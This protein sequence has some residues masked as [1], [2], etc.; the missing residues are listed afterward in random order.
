MGNM[1][2]AGWVE[3][4]CPTCGQPSGHYDTPDQV[5]VSN[6]VGLDECEECVELHET[7]AFVMDLGG[8]VV[9]R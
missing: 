3:Y 5:D 6:G 7:F 2:D 4:T 1:E 9:N 8:F